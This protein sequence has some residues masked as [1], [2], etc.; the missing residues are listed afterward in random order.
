MKVPRVIFIPLM[1]VLEGKVRFPLDPL[2]L[3]TLRYYG[4]S[5]DL[6]LPNFQRVVSDISQLNKSYNLK[7]T[8]HDINFLYS[9]CGSLKNGYNLKVRDPQIRLISCLLD[10]NKN[11]QREFIRV[12]RNQLTDELI[13]LTFPKRAGW[14]P[15]SSYTFYC[16]LCILHFFF[17]LIF[18]SRL[19]LQ[20]LSTPGRTLISLQLQASHLVLNYIPSSTEF[21]DSGVAF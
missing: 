21:Q 12:S 18:S 9:C 13:S 14:L 1:V 20:I 15:E 3:G 7:L 5:P 4:L 2:Q 17:P 11:S 10:S 19:S 8:H 16:F 6:C